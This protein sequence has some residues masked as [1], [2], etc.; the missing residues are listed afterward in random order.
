[1]A[2]GRSGS[3]GCKQQEHEERDAAECMRGAAALASLSMQGGQGCGDGKD[4]VKNRNIGKP[5][6]KEP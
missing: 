5:F 6:H 3:A 2:A 4:Y 1:M